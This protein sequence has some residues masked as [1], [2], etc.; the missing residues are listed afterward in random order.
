LPALPIDAEPL[1]QCFRAARGLQFVGIAEK[2]EDVT[3]T[4]VD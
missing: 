2:E 1:H 4:D 3:P